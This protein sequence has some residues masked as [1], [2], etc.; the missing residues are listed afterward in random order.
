MRSSLHIDRRSGYHPNPRGKEVR[1]DADERAVVIRLELQSPEFDSETNETTWAALVAIEVDG[2]SYA[3][4]GREDLLDLELSVM[5]LRTGQAIRWVD[6]REEWVRSLP[7]AYR[8]PDLIAT[9]VH[10]DNPLPQRDE[11]PTGE[12]QPVGL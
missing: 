8:A 10:D 9:V 7:S 3:I 6:D 12:H 1:L 2:E 5:S 4:E 11:A